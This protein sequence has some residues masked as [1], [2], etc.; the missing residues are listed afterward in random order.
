MHPSLHANCHHHITYEQLVWNYKNANSQVVNKAIEDFNWEEP[1]Q[2]KDFDFDGQA[3]R[4][5]KLVVSSCHKNIPNKHAT[6][7]DKEPPCLIIT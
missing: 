4:F 1:F 6:F 7:N 2:D 5:S 3:H